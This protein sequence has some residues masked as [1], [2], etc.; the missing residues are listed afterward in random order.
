MSDYDWLRPLGLG[1]W[2]VESLTSLVRRLAYGEVRTVP[3]LL[4]EIALEPY[5]SQHRDRH[6]ILQPTRATE[7]INGTTRATELIVDALTRR[8]LV[9]ARRTTLVERDIGI[10]FAPGLRRYRAWCPACLAADAADP[11]DRLLWAFEI[12]ERCPVHDISLID[13]CLKCS[14]PHRPWHLRA[15]PWSCPHCDVPLAQPAHSQPE[16]VSSPIVDLLGLLE[17]GRVPRRAEVTNGFVWLAAS[18]GGLHALSDLLDCSVSGLSTV[19]SGRT[20]P[21]LD[22]L[23]RA[24]AAS[25]DSL[26][27]FLAHTPSSASPHH[28]RGSARPPPNTPALSRLR[29]QLLAASRLAEPPSLRRFAAG[30]LVDPATLRRHLPRLA[31]G[32]VSA[33]DSYVR[34]R[35]SRAESRLA[36]DVRRCFRALAR[37]GVVSRRDLETALGKPGILRSPAARQAYRECSRIDTAA[38]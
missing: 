10:A 28:R 20:R 14:K 21:Q 22:L 7:A 27:T 31:A 9:A 30:H 15:N 25:G 6:L 23:L 24:I 36:E 26:G 17:C 35:R 32:L 2:Q 5:R 13:G 1:T 3:G 37:R 34:T 33:H 16:T 11:Y 12:V 29:L 4:R 38:P 8:K 18:R 19:C